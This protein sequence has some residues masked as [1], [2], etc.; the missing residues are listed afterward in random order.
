[1]A[2]Q[3]LLSSKRSYLSR[4]GHEN[5][6][7]SK[8]RKQKAKEDAREVE[9]M[10]MTDVA[11][12]EL[13]SVK[14]TAS[15]NSWK[16]SSSVRLENSS[17]ATSTGPKRASSKNLLVRARVSSKTHGDE[18][19]ER[20]LGCKLLGFRGS[21][22]LVLAIVIS[23]LLLYAYT[24][25]TARPWYILLVAIL[26]LC[27]PIK[28]AFLI[29]SSSRVKAEDIVAPDTEVKNKCACS[30]IE[31]YD[32][33]GDP[34]GKYYL[35]KTYASE[36]VEYVAQIVAIDVYA[37]SFPVPLTTAIY[38]LLAL[39][40]FAISIDTYW[41]MQH[42]LSVRRRNNRVMADIILEILSSM[43]P[44][45]IMRFAYEL[46]FTELEFAKIALVPACFA[47]LKIHEITE[48]ILR[49]RA[50]QYR[51]L[52][53]KAKRLPFFVNN[54]TESDQN[55]L[56]VQEQM[57]YTPRW[58]H[59]G[60]VT[61]SFIY[62]LFLLSLVIGQMMLR[63]SLQ[64]SVGVVNKQVWDSCK[65]KVPFCKE[66]FSPSCDC[67][68]LNVQKHNWT[69]LPGMIR[70]MTAMKT[71]I[72]N[73]GPLKKLPGLTKLVKLT[74]VHF[75]Y[76][77]LT[78]IPDSLG[79][80]HM[81]YFS[82]I[83]NRL[84]SLPLSVW[85]NPH[86]ISLDL[87][88]NNISSLPS[89]VENADNLRFLFLGNNSF[90][91]FPLEVVQV[92]TLLFLYLDGNYIR[93]LPSE[94]KALHRLSSLTLHNNRYIQSIPTSIGSLATLQRFDVRN[95]NISFLPHEIGSLKNLKYIYLE[96]NPICSN[97][98][99]TAAENIMLVDKIESLSDWGGGCSKQCSQYCASWNLK[100]YPKSCSAECNS[101][102][103]DYH[104]GA[105][106]RN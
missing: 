70:D 74:L 94:I 60:L 61:L 8:P 58:A 21:V 73:H 101:K 34:D 69:T 90:S 51:I 49:E 39:E 97:G 75:N 85:G 76:N 47:L 64:C 41:S 42:G 92:P 65:V 5:P 15:R 50:I 26:A 78:S 24:Q 105:C 53:K 33:C 32:T 28:F 2:L 104:N 95:N 93:S 13:A 100:E 23:G 9:K 66:L 3:D 80:L 48:A 14:R 79:T 7:A 25:F 83:N 81:T 86:L 54:T 72:V 68:V 37:C 43:V 36:I 45:L 29:W 88:N 16:D 40:A 84:K 11:N 87:S 55:Q 52:K 19:K 56:L 6:F 44:I 89:D 102:L 91:K 77:H 27:I 103:C 18:R 4:H 98:W 99:V 62:G 59:L 17:E 30:L 12:V 20:C 46:E 96:N 1:V 106:Q 82:A 10:S 31:M 22:C 38:T 63:P 67:A 35:S 71:I 57:R